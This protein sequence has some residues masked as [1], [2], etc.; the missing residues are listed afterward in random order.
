MSPI[1]RQNKR[2]QPSGMPRQTPASKAIMQFNFPSSLSLSGADNEID[3]DIWRPVLMRCARETT[4]PFSTRSGAEEAFDNLFE[5]YKDSILI[6]SYSSN[7]L[8]TRDEMVEILSKYKQHVEVIPIDY[9]Y[10]F[11]NQGDAKTHRNSV[12]EYLFV[13][14]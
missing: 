7:S 3:S 9:T 2:A 12:Q 4:T 1:T 5:K 13:G 14:F 10:S 6:V 11:G 8:P